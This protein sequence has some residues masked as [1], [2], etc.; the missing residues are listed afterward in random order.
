MIRKLLRLINGVSL[1]ALLTLLR[2]GPTAARGVI[3]ATNK[4]ATRSPDIHKLDAWFLC[5][6]FPSSESLHIEPS[7]WTD[8]TTAPLERL[9]IASLTR[10]FEPLRILEIGTYRGTTT[11][12]LL[13]NAP[14]EATIWSLDLP[15]DVDYDALVA[16][17]D[18]HLV[19]HRRVVS[20]LSNHP[21]GDAVKLLHGDSMRPETWDM[22]PSE[23]D[24]VFI[25]ASHTYEAV[26][27]D[28]E[29]TFN[30]LKD[31]GIVLWHDYS[32]GESPQRG[33]GRYIRELMRQRKDVF[34]CP[35]TALAFRIPVNQ[36]EAARTRIEAWFPAHDFDQRFPSDLLPWL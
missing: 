7:D 35:E 13:D 34:I 6:G 32:D 14:T 9:L 22:V 20:A 27:N 4:A 24:L 25:D 29:R 16:A 30:A 18:E 31:T 19:K 26:R 8:G 3:G 5:R 33:V 11:R 1:A 12:L 17:S 36:L 28:S 2:R 15:L 21:R 10:H 23:L